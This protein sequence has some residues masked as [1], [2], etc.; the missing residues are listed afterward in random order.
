MFPASPAAARTPPFAD[1]IASAAGV[2]AG[3]IDGRTPDA[4]ISALNDAVRPAVADLALNTLRD[5]GRGDFLLA[6]LLARPLRAG[7]ASRTRQLRA[8]LLCAL[9]R[10]EARPEAAHTIVDQSVAAA[11]RLIGAQ[12]APLVNGV[13]RSFLRERAA[14]LAA[15]D[16]DAVARWR[17]PAWW[18]AQLQA[19]HAHEWQAIAAA[20][21]THPPMSLRL[22]GRRPATT[23]VSPALSALPHRVLPGG[24]WLLDTPMPVARLPG[25]ADGACSVQ[26]AGAQLAAPLLD[27][28]DGMRVLDA[29]AAPGGKTAHLLECAAIDLLALELDGGRAERVRANL[30]RLGLTADVRVADARDPDTWWDGRPFERILADVPC[31]AS[32]VVRRHPD[33]KWLRRAGDIDAFADTQRQIIDVLWRTLAPDGKMLYATCSVFA[34][35][36]SQQVAAFLARHADARLEP[37]QPPGSPIIATELQLLPTAEHDGFFY[38]LLAKQP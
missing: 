6:R 24:A 32:G 27:V 23:V 28:R 15:A 1:V 26:D 18:L 33:A 20:G 8:L 25:F 29:C 36:N 35:E 16:G 38:A 12:T 21:N 9:H 22:N 10:L 3:V 19:D 4:A 2:V 37:L 34:R 17:H 30:A 31:S 7:D 11:R 5:F 14:L 13:L